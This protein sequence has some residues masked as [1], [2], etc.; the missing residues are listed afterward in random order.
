MISRKKSEKSMMIGIFRQIKAR[1]DVFYANI[2][3]GK[4]AK[5]V[6]LTSQKTSRPCRLFCSCSLC[7]YNSQGCWQQLYHHSFSSTASYDFFYVKTY[8]PNKKVNNVNDFLG[9]DKTKE[10]LARKLTFS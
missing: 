3:I 10:F 5:S 8:Y 6:R 9:G 7:H 4:N 1:S 2:I